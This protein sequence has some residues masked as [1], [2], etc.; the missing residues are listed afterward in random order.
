LTPRDDPVF[1][2]KL[3]ADF[4]SHDPVFF[5]NDTK[6]TALACVDR[7]TICDPDGKHCWHGID[8]IPKDRGGEALQSHIEKTGYYMLDI[9]TWKSS[10]CNAISLR[11]GSALEAQ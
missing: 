4:P 7:L 9:A 8:E 11:G 1:P 2:A 5:N 6:A 10:I 3:Q